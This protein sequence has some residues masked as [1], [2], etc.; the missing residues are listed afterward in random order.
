MKRQDLEEDQQ[1]QESSPTESDTISLDSTSSDDRDTK[2]FLPDVELEDTAGGSEQEVVV[3][4]V[5]KPPLH[6]KIRKLFLHGSFFVVG[7][8]ILVAGGV[9]SRYHPYVDPE[10]YYNCSTH[11]N[12]SYFSDVILDNA[13]MLYSYNQ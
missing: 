8:C 9:A 3:H 7:V 12:S 11:D 5:L 10:E 13:T 2:S 1:Q 4:E 6:Y